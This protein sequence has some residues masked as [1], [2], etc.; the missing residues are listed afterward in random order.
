MRLQSLDRGESQ[1]DC[2]ACGAYRKGAKAAS[3]ECLDG[4]TWV[5]AKRRWMVA[6]VRHS[7]TADGDQNRGFGLGWEVAVWEEEDDVPGIGNKK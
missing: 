1:V 6:G 7:P 5:A 4:W 3:G 2:S